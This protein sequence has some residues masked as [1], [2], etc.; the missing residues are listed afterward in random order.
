MEP[1]V[2]TAETRQ[3]T[4]LLATFHELLTRPL[5]LLDRASGGGLRLALPLLAGSVVAY[6]LYGAAAG[7]FQGG[8]QILVTAVKTP[9]IILLSI[10][11]CLPSLFVFAALAGARWTSATFLAIL[12]GFAG[13]LAL[14]LLALLPISWLFS[15]SSRHLSTAVFLQFTLWIVALLLTWRFLRQALDALG[16][17]AGALFL[18]LALFC[19]VSLQ[20]TTML[21]P[22]LER[23]PGAPLFETGKKSFLE[24]MGDTVFGEED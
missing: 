3:T 13:T 9:L 20:V 11:L 23:K 4:G 6:V 2:P 8:P 19:I 5:A 22:V 17:N 18:W 21:R 14:I 12:S 1:P 7:F 10:L 15:A 16:A 24:H